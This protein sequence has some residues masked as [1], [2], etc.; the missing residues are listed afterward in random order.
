[1][2]MKKNPMLP[3]AGG[4]CPV[5]P[6][7]EVEI[8]WLHCREGVTKISRAGDVNWGHR[9]LVSY[10]VLG[11]AQVRE[12]EWR[13]TFDDMNIGRSTTSRHLMEPLIPRPPG[14]EKNA[15]WYEWAGKVIDLLN[16]QAAPSASVA[17]PEQ[18]RNLQ[19]II[20]AEE[21]MQ[22]KCA[23]QDDL[24]EVQTLL[25]P[26]V[27][28]GWAV[29]VKRL[30]AVARAAHFAMEDSEV[31]TDGRHL[32]EV[33]EARALYV[34][35]EEL[36]KLPDNPDFMMSCHEKAEWALRD[37]LAAPKEPT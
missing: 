13:Y 16:A 32:L 22:I 26:V 18:V 15:D 17:L 6:D 20:E 23:L 9:G 37:L 33:G 36:D 27:P 30:L 2:E 3:W 1:M 11:A 7:V 24:D 29:A 14:F 5:G 35:L 4:A 21:S 25:G 12:G 28:D 8:Q 34:A 10:R 31:C 19:R